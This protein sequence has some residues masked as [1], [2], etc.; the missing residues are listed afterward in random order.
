[1]LVRRAASVVTNRDQFCNALAGQL[2]ESRARE[3][4]L[5]GM[6]RVNIVRS[7]S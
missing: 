4:F 7:A 5:A 3:A 1:V 2:D 6:K